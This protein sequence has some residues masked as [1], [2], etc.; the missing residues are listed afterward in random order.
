MPILCQNFYENSI[1][2]N[3]ISLETTE[4]LRPEFD[5][6]NLQN[7]Q[8]EAS[9]IIVSK[10]NLPKL[11]AFIQGGYG[12]PALNMLNNSFEAFYV[13][14]IRLNWTLFDWNKTKKE[15]EVLEISKQLIASEK[16]TFQL[17]L[18]RQLQETD[19]EIQKINQQLKSDEEIIDLRQKIVKSSEAQ[20]KNGVITTS[21]YLNE[22][23]K[24]F[25]SKNNQKS[26]QIQLQLTQANYQ[27]IK[28]N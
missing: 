16:E 11:N 14:G 27:I 5:F 19:F 26:H 7:Q 24:L 9:Q 20:M 22:I 10:S 21:E 1:L 8:L 3:S 6:F 18:N 2:E 28:G 17:N 13:T 12:N 23:D 25:E 15:K 4:A